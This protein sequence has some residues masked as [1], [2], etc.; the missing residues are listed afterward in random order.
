MGV[1]EL[2]DLVVE[3]VSEEEMMLLPNTVAKV[4]PSCLLVSFSAWRVN[5]GLDGRACRCRGGRSML[6]L[7]FFPLVPR[8]NGRLSQAVV[9]LVTIDPL[10]ILLLLAL[11][12][13]KKE[14]LVN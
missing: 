8:A 9:Q 13:E 10:N 3:C 12:H 11:F 14:V 5:G 2:L 1:L 7:P 4:S 6:T